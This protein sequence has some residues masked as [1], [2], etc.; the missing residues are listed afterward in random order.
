MNENKSFSFLSFLLFLISY[1][2]SFSSN[3]ERNFSFSF[4]LSFSRF[5]FLSSKLL[6]TTN[7][8]FLFI[9]FQQKLRNATT[10]LFS[11]VYYF[12][13]PFLFF[14]FFSSWNEKHFLSIYSLFFCFPSLYFLFIYLMK[15]RWCLFFLRSSSW[16]LLFAPRRPHADVQAC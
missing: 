2:F 13:S 4:L 3:L 15:L 11:F 7:F 8:D 12:I 9:S 6:N 1:F 16:P 10:L 5:L 14:L